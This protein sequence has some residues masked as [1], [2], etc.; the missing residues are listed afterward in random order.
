MIQPVDDS[1]SRCVSVHR[2]CRW[3]LLCLLL[4]RATISWM[5]MY[6]P[7]TKPTKPMR[8]MPMSLTISH[9]FMSS[10]WKVMIWSRGGM[11]RARALLLT[12]PTRE[13]TRSSSGINTARA[14]AVRQQRNITLNTWPLL[15]AELFML[16]ALYHVED[17]C[18]RYFIPN[19]FYSEHP[20]IVKYR[21][22]I[23]W[24]CVYFRFVYN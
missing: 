23:K 24:V 3:V 12:E 5:E 14:P 10:L 7:A 4:F 16:F 18:T 9:S 20:V 8:L 1:I 17:G 2:S 13:I 19:M 11:M 15:A 6:V 21:L 22:S